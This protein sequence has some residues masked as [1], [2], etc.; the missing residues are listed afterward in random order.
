MRITLHRSHDGG[1]VVPYVIMFDGAHAE[2][3]TAKVASD[4]LVMAEDLVARGHDGVRITTPLGDTYPVKQFA[5]LL[6]EG[7]L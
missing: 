7:A 6:R 3:L 1:R 4:A 2:A 5:A